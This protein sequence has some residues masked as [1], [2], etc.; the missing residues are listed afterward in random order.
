LLKL[1]LREA[2]LGETVGSRSITIAKHA[3]VY[4][5]SD[6]EQMVHFVERGQIKLLM[7]SPEGKECLLAIHTSGDFLVNYAWPGRMHVW[8]PRPP[9]KK[10]PHA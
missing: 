4:N 9:W 7:L 1:H 8:K 3:N 6:E 2:F 10:R 5:C